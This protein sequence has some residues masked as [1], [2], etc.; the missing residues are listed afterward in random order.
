MYVCMYA[1][2]HAC[3]NA[4]H[5]VCMY[6]TIKPGHLHLKSTAGILSVGILALFAKR[7]WCFDPVVFYLLGFDPQGIFPRT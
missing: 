2:M 6:K 3:M 4:C 7:D 5:H 1:T